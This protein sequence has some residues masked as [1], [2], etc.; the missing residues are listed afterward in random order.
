MVEISALLFIILGITIYIVILA[1]VCALIYIPADIARLKGRSVYVWL[2][3]SVI[4]FPLALI[5]SYHFLKPDKD[6][7]LYNKNECKCGYCG[8]SLG[9]SGKLVVN[10]NDCV[11]CPSCKKTTEKEVC[12]VPNPPGEKI[13]IIILTISSIIIFIKSIYL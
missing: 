2:W 9:K 4:L 6:G 10:E 13:L 5:H 8:E 11:V 1:A 3:Y 12:K 7:I